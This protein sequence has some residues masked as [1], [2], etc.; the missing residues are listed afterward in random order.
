MAE[1]FLKLREFTGTNLVFGSDKLY[2]F[3][4][5]MYGTKLY[6]ASRVHLW[7]AHSYESF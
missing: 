6:V 7:L 5:M 2:L 3:V 4:V 1:S